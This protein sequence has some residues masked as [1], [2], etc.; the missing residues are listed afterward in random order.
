MRFTG[1]G[2]AV[3]LLAGR[4]AAGEWCNRLGIDARRWPQQ[5]PPRLWLPL[6]LAPAET[7]VRFA[8][9]RAHWRELMVVKCRVPT[10]PDSAASD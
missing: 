9:C 3:F 2:A 10:V 5:K 6:K 4:A 7:R 8:A 1:S